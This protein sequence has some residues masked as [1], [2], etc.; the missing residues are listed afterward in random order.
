MGCPH[1]EL[2]SR[3]RL[4]GD[5][6][7][8]GIDVGSTTVKAVAVDPE[9]RAILWSHYERHETRQAEKVLEQLV[10]I[11][12]AFPHVAP[13]NVRTFLT[14]SGSGPLRE[15]LGSRFVQE[16]NAVTMA[17]DQLHPDVGSVVELGGQDAKIIIFKK[18][19]KTGDR[20]AV[21][22]MNDKCA[23]GTGATIDKCIIKVGMAEEQIG[24]LAW[25][26]S[27]LHRVAAKCGV[28]AETDIVNLVKSGIRPDEIL[29]S[30]ADAIVMQNLSVL[31]RGH[32]LRHKVLLLGG[33]NTYL[34]FLQACWR[35]RI[36]EAWV[37]RG[38]DYP[39][40]VPVEELIFVPENAEYYAAFGAA[41]YG[42]EETGE[43]GVFQG[44]DALKRFIRQ[45]R[46]SALGQSAGPSLVSTGTE[47]M[48]FR[49]E[50]TIPEFELAAFDPG[51]EVRG[52]IG[53]DG[54]ST[55][56]KAVL[57]DEQGEILCKAYM[58]SKGNPIADTQHLLS[59][60]QGFVKGQ[61]AMLQVLGFGATGYAGN[62]LEESMR[63]DV[64][65]VETIAHMMSAL[66]YEKKVDVICDVGGQDIKVLFLVDGEIRNFRLSNQCSAGNGML[67][68]AMAN[69]FGIPITK[70]ADTAFRA[71]RSPNF[72]YGCA[73][74]LDADRVNF[75]KEGFS[76]EEL[77]AGLALVLPKNIW[78]YVVQIPRMA[79]LGVRYVLQGGTQYNLAALK[80]QVDYIRQRVPEAEVLVHP[81]PGE[82]G[83]IGAAMESRRVVQRRG[84][85]TFIGLSAALGLT[86]TTRHDEST[87]CNFC[88]NHC[89]R[90]FTETHTPE[91][92]TSRYI[93]GFN[94]E[95]GAVES[96]ETL[97]KLM[98][99]RS[100]IKARF[101]NLVEYESKLAF[102]S[103]YRPKAM[104]KA[105]DL[106]EDV[107][108]K[109]G[110][111]GR[112]KRR[113]IRRPMQRSSA[114]ALEKRREL[115]IGIPRV[116][117]IYSSAPIWRAYF[118]TLGVPSHHVVFSDSTSEEMWA[119]GGRYG[120]IDPC[121]PAK[122]AQAHVHNLLFRKHAKKKLDY[123]FFP[124]I[125]HM[126]T[127]VTGVMDSASCPIVAGAPKVI[128]AAFTKEVDFFARAGIDYVDGAVTLTERHYFAKQMFE[129]FGERLGVTEDESNFACRQGF[130]ALQR[131]DDDLQ[132]RGREIL[133]G[134]EA[135]NKVGVLLLG[136]PYHQDPGLNHGVLD[137]FQALGYPILS[138]RSI[139][140]D[141]KWL[142]RFF[143]D[144]LT[145]GFVDS[146]MEV[147]DVWPENYSTNSVQKV[148]A[149]K[150]AAR[151]PNI[152]VLDLSSFKCGQD[153]PTY[154]M[155]DSVISA[156]RT[157]YSA[158]HDIDA[159]KPG[160]SIQIRVKTYAHRL[161]L[162]EEE[163][164]DLAS[165]RSE[166]EKRVEAKRQAL[167][168]SRNL[169]FQ[170]AA[171]ENASLREE[172]VQM[173]A[174]YREYLEE[175]PVLPL[176]SG[177]G[178][179]H[180]D[181]GPPEPIGVEP[182]PGRNGS[183][184]KIQTKPLRWARDRRRTRTDPTE[185]I[186]P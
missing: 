182:C 116:L 136:R 167:L 85:S 70:Y 134:L 61:G 33:P 98:R 113:P 37:A 55:S 114:A 34:P 147:T 44:V 22:S 184:L 8:L 1:D 91:G 50:Y 176:F 27:K 140:K 153:A 56:S 38:Y 148:W 123:I 67:L 172:V 130:E 165:R 49:K 31:T 86:Y 115:R 32:S 73:V 52:F 166:L 13:G 93:S 43:V 89:A 127:F 48:E 144:D 111:F 145:R 76:K 9:T 108:V 75:Q 95:K 146:P 122:V 142:T 20:R 23:S 152:V 74:F 119:E 112:I 5:C 170:N 17:V 149:A 26:P 88:S 59:E 35:Q 154:G 179:G 109:R 10:A 124:C 137:E 174:A 69:Q 138:I 78:Q 65:I 42:L 82:A 15:P 168:R 128:R 57:I 53:L 64:N 139:P 104:P 164:T 177:E 18:N 92:G 83:A 96:K 171:L 155:I 133:E 100:Q 183:L 103:F 16:V 160:G 66:K 36:P 40:D 3:T 125:T 186:S 79:Q 19:G 71:R 12:N 60:I 173:Q 51:Q 28:F 169:K 30:L 141:P 181:V 6:L 163:L 126:P 58:L 102:H 110:L 162:Y 161:S 135:E 63:A 4:T 47:L 94:C 45:G 121:Y 157:P 106:I 185:R 77:L 105:G 120:S 68:Q 99:E 41:I 25:D 150:F 46:E 11:G 180:A 14:G 87:A 131:F 132:R 101:P 117:N 21:A 24:Q 159:N 54:G 156:S 118:E 107:E 97:K 62:L 7:I 151:H 178:I 29:C 80:A 175:T 81:H 158:L 2:S 84:Y 72:S 143:E 90:T 39:E 129:M